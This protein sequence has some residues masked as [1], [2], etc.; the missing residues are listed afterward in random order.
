MTGLQK[1]ATDHERSRST[2]LIEHS[3][4]ASK[5]NIHVIGLLVLVIL[6]TNVPCFFTLN[7]Y[8]VWIETKIIAKMVQIGR[9]NV[10]IF[11]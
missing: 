10:R 1:A 5:C 3:S 4:L 11:D 2:G 9:P 7:A 6:M 8:S